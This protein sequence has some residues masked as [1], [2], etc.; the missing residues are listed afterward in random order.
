MN[1][2]DTLSQCK[3]SILINE[4][5]SPCKENYTKYIAIIFDKKSKYEINSYRSGE[6]EKVNNRKNLIIK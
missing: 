6:I 5:T 4:I 2:F 1:T 3:S